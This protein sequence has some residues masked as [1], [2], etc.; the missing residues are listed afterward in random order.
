[1]I[2][3][4]NH[5]GQMKVGEGD[6]GRSGRG[7]QKKILSNEPF[8]CSWNRTYQHRDSCRYTEMKEKIKLCVL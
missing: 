5:A 3:F 2:L 1:M 7:F 8:C 6:G 4:S